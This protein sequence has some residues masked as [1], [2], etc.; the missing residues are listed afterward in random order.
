MKVR[1]WIEFTITEKQHKQG[2]YKNIITRIYQ[3]AT[4]LNRQSIPLYLIANHVPEKFTNLVFFL[5]L[6]LF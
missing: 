1:K 5:I 6:R 2:L 3:M 4:T